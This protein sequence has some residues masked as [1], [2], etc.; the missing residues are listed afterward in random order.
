MA[1]PVLANIRVRQGTHAE[2]IAADPTLLAGEVAFV[3]DAKKF[4][5][6]D[7]LNPYS[8]LDFTY[9]GPYLTADRHEAIASTVNAGELNALLASI[10]K[11][12]NGYDLHIDMADGDYVFDDFIR[13]FGFHGGNVYINGNLTETDATE[14]HTTQAVTVTCTVTASQSSWQGAFDVRGGSARVIVQDIKITIADAL[15]ICNIFSDGAVCQVK[16]CYLLGSGVTA[17]ASYGFVALDASGQMDK[18]YLSN[19]RIGVTAAGCTVRCNNCSSTGTLP[20]FGMQGTGGGNVITTGSEVTGSYRQMYVSSGGWVNADKLYANKTV[21]I[22]AGTTA[23]EFT[24]IVNDQPKNLNGYNLTFQF[25]DGTYTWSSRITVFNGFVG[26]QIVIAGNSAD[27]T[28]L[29]TVHSV[30]ITCSDTAT[31]SGV[32]NFYQCACAITIQ[33]MK[34]TGAD[35]V[36][37]GYCVYADTVNRLTVQYCYLNHAATTGSGSAGVRFNNCFGFINLTYFSGASAGCSSTNALTRMDNCA[38]TGTLPLIGLSASVAGFIGVNGTWCAGSTQ[39]FAESGGGV[40]NGGRLLANLTVNFDNSMTAAQV[41]TIIGSLPKNL[42]GKTLTLQFA[43]GTYTFN[44][45]IAVTYFFGGIINIYGV[46]AEGTTAYTTQTVIWNSTTA[47]TVRNL[48]VQYNACRVYIR[49]IRFN[50]PDVADARGVEMNGNNY[51]YVEACYA[52]GA[53]KTNANYGFSSFN[54]IS[55]V[56]N[57]YVSNVQYGILAQRGIL[58]SNTNPSTGTNPNY[59][60]RASEGARIAKNSTQPTGT[61]ANETISTFGEIG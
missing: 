25:A 7:A 3:T 20:Y 18:T 24:N 53:A 37:G 59:G 47:S 60:L 48:S 2:W 35:N 30:N 57:T 55:T 1:D 12:L 43:A 52:A 41:N 54:Q 49:N 6:G 45:N 58:Y 10:P 15:G 36:A 61:T 23:A 29:H 8:V 9:T 26:G 14:L 13:L 19:M 34:I 17:N 32:F 56:L 11:N 27:G 39:D 31:T 46:T 51:A 28:A 33:Y 22:P 44:A 5:I 50:V 16:Y 4:K 21:N 38:S 42:N 40:I